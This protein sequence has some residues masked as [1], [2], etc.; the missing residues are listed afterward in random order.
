MLD[1]EFINIDLFF[2]PIFFWIGLFLIVAFTLYSYRY[3]IPALEKFKKIPL[4]FLRST[5]LV[6]ILLAIFE[7][8]INVGKRIV[9]EPKNMVFIDNS[10]SISLKDSSDKT[11][12]LAD[13]INLYEKNKNSEIYTFGNGI[14][15]YSSENLKLNEAVTNFES[16]VKYIETNNKNL[17]TVTILSDGSIT[18]GSESLNEIKK[19]AI[20][21]YTVGIGEK[22]S[23]KDISIKKVDYNEYIYSNKPTE[24]SAIINSSDLENTKII[25]SL[26]KGNSVIEQKEVAINKSGIN[27]ASFSYIPKNFGE[28][29]LTVKI[30]QVADEITYDNNQKSFFI[31]VLKS[32]IKVCLLTGSPSPDVSFI[33]NILNK[34]DN[35]EIMSL[36]QISST[37]FIE[38]NSGLS[39]IDSSDIL[40]LIGFP[41][42]I[43]NYNIIQKVN[44]AIKT[45]PFL[46]TLSEGTDFAKLYA[47]K[48]NIPFSFTSYNN[49]FIESRIEVVDL[50]SPLLKNNSQDHILAWNQ[51]P[52]IYKA[53]FNISPKQGCKNI[54]VSLLNNQKT[55]SSLIITRQISDSKSIALLFKDVWR[56]KL[57]ASD[58]NAN[59]LDNF[60]LQSV[61]WLNA[62]DD[63]KRINISSQKKIYSR[64]EIV[65]FAAKIYDETFTPVTNAEIELLIKSSDEKFTLA[66]EN[67]NGTYES[68]L[69]TINTG[70]YSFTGT[71]KIDGVIIGTDKGKFTIGDVEVEKTS[72][73][74]NENF[75]K[76]IADISGGKYFH[77][78]NYN[79]IFSEIENITNKKRTFIIEEKDFSLWSNEYLVI[80]IIFIFSVEWFLRKRWGLL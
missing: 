36:S 47:L 13:F 25:A 8:V 28:E 56:L 69:E 70:D 21:I 66:L 29:K 77:I 30:S 23:G 68:S 22:I 31:N 3:T 44:E 74:L 11:N 63:K 12:K 73:S 54:A 32:K 5:A 27:K 37:K 6:L 62:K 19:L 55:N 46:I 45:K 17:S 40:F 67:N 2:S 58:K 72:H 38:T 59:V 24:I 41:S 80:I 7:P 18:D 78:N 52:P 76:N 10:R 75:L 43:T 50:I 49:N 35:L 1:I 53:A 61:K 14:R 39:V 64:G 26:L 42:S 79:G 51:L 9:R 15:E 71:V 16:I 65:E 4:I 33:R 60:I 34:D 57:Q 20:P 48:N